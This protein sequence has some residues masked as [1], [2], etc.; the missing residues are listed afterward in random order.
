MS[1]RR[2][3]D[4]SDHLLRTYPSP[5]QRAPQPIP[6]FDLRNPTL[7]LK[8]QLIKYPL[9][10]LGHICYSQIVG[11]LIAFYSLDF[12]SPDSTLCR[13]GPF[14]SPGPPPRFLKAIPKRLSLASAASCG[15]TPSSAA[16]ALISARKQL[17]GP[18]KPRLPGSLKGHRLV[19]VSEQNSP[20]SLSLPRL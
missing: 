18:A 16:A 14:K 4:V 1:P 12:Q 17:F 13:T 7:I 11:K 10:G 3:T 5:F 9:T 15:C 8:S 19:D 2:V 6:Y 20:L